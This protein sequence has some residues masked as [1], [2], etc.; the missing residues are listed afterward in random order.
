MEDILND[1]IIYDDDHYINDCSS[2]KRKLTI[3][4][5]VFIIISSLLCFPIGIFVCNFLPG[6]LHTYLNLNEI[7]NSIAP[8]LAGMM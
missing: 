8:G 7:A 2:Y 5:K 1:S 4:E 3:I 6:D